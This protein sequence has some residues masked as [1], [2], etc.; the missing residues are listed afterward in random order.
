MNKNKKILVIT[1]TFPRWQGDLEPPFVYEL[2]KRLSKNYTVHLLA[3]HAQGAALCEHFNNINVTRFRYFFTKYQTLAYNGGILSRLKQN[4]WRYLLVPFFIIA[5]WFAIIRLLRR[6]N[7]DLIHAHWLVPQGFVALLAT[8]FFKK[9]PPILCTSH[10]GDLF[11]LQGKLFKK[12]KQWVLKRS[13]AIT[14]VSQAMRETALSLGADAN[15][16]EVI[17]M[18]VDLKNQFIPTLAGRDG[19]NLLFVGRLVEKKGLDSLLAALPLII[20]QYPNVILTIAGSGPDELKL[21]K[22]VVD[23]N[24]NNSVKFLGAVE[25]EQLPALYQSSEIVVFP[26]IIAADG[27]REGFGLVL[28]EALGC[29]SAVVASDLP[30]MQ[31]I[32]T[33]NKN[34]FIFEQKNSQQLAEKVNYLLSNPQLR[35]SLGKQG[36]QDM[37][38][39]Y[40]WE[41]ITER[42]ST[43]MQHVMSK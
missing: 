13:S 5:E 39:R 27:D 3:P 31:D 41:M 14:V 43:L 12:L 34:A 25:N 7:F 23:L 17:S 2:S 22:Q 36:R 16:I 37:L 26:S 24:I 19:N 15:K 35:A 18:G 29:E 32:L 30:A 20:N 42:Y 38:E 10:G 8:V 28:V 4:R 11:G 40:D 6:E 9:S 1:S 21:K 33:D